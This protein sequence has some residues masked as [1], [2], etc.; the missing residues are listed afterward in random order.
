ML[1][2]VITSRPGLP[3]LLRDADKMAVPEAM[4][5]VAKQGQDMTGH[6]EH[7]E[8]GADIGVRGIAASKEEAFVQAALALSAVITEPSYNFV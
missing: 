6:W 3:Y 5:A 1:Y 2:E 7:F 4:P 8:H